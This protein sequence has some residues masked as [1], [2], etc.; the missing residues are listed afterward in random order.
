[1]I[2]TESATTSPA[3]SITGTR[4]WPEIASTGRR[5]EYS[6]STDCASIPL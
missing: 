3:S 5:F 4:G 6:I 1:M 2:S